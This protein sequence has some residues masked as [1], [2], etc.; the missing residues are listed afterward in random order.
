MNYD[1]FKKL[2]KGM[3]CIWTKADFLPDGYAVQMWYRLLRDLTYE[4]CAVAVERYAILNKFPPTIAEIREQAVLIQT[5]AGDWSEGW[6]EVL[7][8]VGRFGQYREE[9][10]LAS[11]NGITAEA[12]RRLGWK[13]ICRAEQDELTAIRANFRMIYEQAKAT[14][15]ENAALPADLKE[16][17]EKIGGGAP[18]IEERKDGVT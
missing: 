1:D 14:E 7:K 8:A 5:D 11:M 12:V 18:M 16:R 3:K 10:A 4:Q 15:K 9:E 6:R 13:Q 2:V 17:I